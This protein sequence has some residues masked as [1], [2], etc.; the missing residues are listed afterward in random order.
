MLR[1]I[2]ITLLFAF[3]LG[4]SLTHQAKSGSRDDVQAA[5]NKAQ[6]GDTVFIPAGN[7]VF[8]GGVSLKGGITI[9][10]AGRDKTTLRRT[11]S[12]GTYMFTVNCSNGGQLVITGL[13]IVGL[14][15]S[16]SPGI[17]LTNNCKNFRIY[18]NTF[19]KCMDR[20]I[21]I[22][23]DTRG[24]IDHNIFIDNNLT[25][26]V[27]FGDGDKGWQ[28]P[29]EL[30]SADAVYVED[31]YFRQE[32]IASSNMH[33]HIASNNGSRYVFRY[34]ECDDG[35]LA[36]SAVDAHGNKFYWPR[37]SRGYEVYGNT[38][39]SGRRWVCIN[40][41][42]GD[43]VIFDNK[44]FGSYSYPLQIMHEGRQGDGNCNYPCV[45]QIRKLYIW[46]NTYEDKRFEIRT[47]HPDIIKLNRDYFLTEMPGYKPYAYPHPLTKSTELTDVAYQHKNR[48]SAKTG[49]INFNNV[50]NLIEG[51]LSQEFSGEN[52]KI[53]IFNAQGK[54][55][56]EISGKTNQNGEFR[57]G[58]NDQ[59]TSLATGVYTLQL[60][61][62]SLELQKPLIISR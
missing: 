31:N 5:I 13:T 28:R 47:P 35:N 60:R 59:H 22:H 33:H 55:V 36:S 57:F 39:K 9:M 52:L 2:T 34:N 14:S 18:D 44:F 24:V 54:L 56:R 38:F 43:G 6:I 10:G 12:G 15:P 53:R 46:N 41:R 61:S 11:S 30:G 48:L 19:R 45:D 26:I 58:L 42:G 3:S 62:G 49:Y 23:G 4:N 25:A 17:K 51:Q 32:N 37:G 40:I 21:E 8:N 27:V 50:N 16:M 1:L 7:F 29:L 20:A